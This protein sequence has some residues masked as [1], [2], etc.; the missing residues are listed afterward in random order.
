MESRKTSDREDH[1]KKN[2]AHEDSDGHLDGVPSKE[3]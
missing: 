3:S 2:G 1:R